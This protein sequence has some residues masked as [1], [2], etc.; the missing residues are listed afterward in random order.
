MPSFEHKKIAEQLVRLDELPSGKE[1]MAEWVQAEAHLKFL[2]SNKNSQEIVIY[3]SPEYSFIY[4][5]VVPEEI[6][7]PLDKTDLLGWSVNPYVSAASYVWGGGR[8]DVWVERGSSGV[9]SKVLAKGSHLIYGRTF[10]G[11]NGEDR[12]YFEL[13]QEYA[14]LEGL[15]WRPEQR[16]YCRFDEQGDLKP[17]VSITKRNSK[18]EISLVTF[19]R[20]SID[21]YLA[22]SRQVLVRLFDFTLLDRS[23][24]SSWGNGDETVINSSDALFYRQRIHG[25]AAYTRGVQIIKPKRPK[26]VIFSD[27][28][29]EFYSEKEKNHIG[30]IAYDWRNSRV[31]EISTD[32]EDTVNYFEAENNDL[33]F[34]LSPAFFKPEV[35]L[36]YKADKDKYTVGERDIHC[37]AAWYLEAFDV[38]EA[39]QVF[40]YICYLRRLPE[41]ELLHW[42]SYN[43]PPKAPISERAY[44]NDFE[45]QW[46]SY[47]DPLED[48]K[49]ICREWERK[50][51]SWW[52]LKDDRLIEN[53]TVPHTASRDEWGESFLALTQLVNEGFVVKPL[54]ELLRENSVTFDKQEGSLSLLEKLINLDESIEE[55]I[56]LSGLRTAQLIRTKAK[57][58]SAKNDSEKL[59]MDALSEHETYG[60]HFRYICEIISDELE[61][62]QS[63][64]ESY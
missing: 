21:S 29:G 16:G 14:H 42:K 6:L 62:I 56:R 40:A 26:S 11:W 28:K 24:F 50:R 25:N 38:N 36:K 13:S 34:E 51:Y 32:P 31:R 60:S 18:N 52:K 33:P 37:R 17:V 49:K 47:T 45:G 8:D 3:G 27:M 19:D 53:A 1:A 39:G 59:S 54:R 43:E 61:I 9:G 30:F 7:E 4:S 44:T 22:A 63:K 55:P 57:G 41:S 15:H 58:H 2:E 23:N 12:D 46:V 64:L 35:L 10:E 5:M 20:L 48:I